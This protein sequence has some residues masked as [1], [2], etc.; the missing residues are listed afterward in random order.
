MTSSEKDL[1]RVLLLDYVF[2]A[3]YELYSSQDMGINKKFNKKK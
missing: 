3:F 1:E 2:I